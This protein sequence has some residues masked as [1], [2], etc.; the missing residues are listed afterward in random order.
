M[1]YT[2]ISRNMPGGVTGRFLALGDW[3]PTLDD[4][5]DNGWSGVHVGWDARRVHGSLESVQCELGV[6]PHFL[7]ILDGYFV[8]CCTM[9]EVFNQFGGHYDVV[10]FDVPE[11]NRMLWY[12]ATG[13][14]CSPRIYVMPDDGHNE[15]VIKL[16]IHRGYWNVTVE[17]RLVMVHPKPVIAK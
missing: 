11:K 13:Q 16:A 10:W 17:G 8:K 7:R 2:H 14:A 3:S 4:L 1:I 5:L 12:T 9:S 6:D 15:D